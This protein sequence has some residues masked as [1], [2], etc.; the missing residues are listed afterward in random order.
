[1]KKVNQLCCGLLPHA[2][3]DESELEWVLRIK[4]FRQNGSSASCAA[5]ATACGG[6]LLKGITIPACCPLLG[7]FSK[8]AERSPAMHAQKRSVQGL[9]GQNKV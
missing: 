1:M 6:L 2:P 3:L 9:K 8:K 5:L 4:F 7:H